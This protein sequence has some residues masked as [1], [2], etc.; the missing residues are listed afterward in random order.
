MSRLN[1]YCTNCAHL[2]VYKS[3]RVPSISSPE[4][5]N[6]LPFWYGDYLDEEE[7]FNFTFE[8]YFHFLVDTVLEPF[9]WC[10]YFTASSL[11]VY[12][13]ASGLN[14]RNQ[15]LNAKLQLKMVI[16]TIN[17]VRHFLN[18]ITDTLNT[19][20]VEKLSCNRPYQNQYFIVI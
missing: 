4:I 7:N 10:L 11:S 6:V 14:N 16:D 19:I 15:N 5:D 8:R 20:L 17:C 2:C 18:S 3:R 9:L 13:N 12:S 1:C